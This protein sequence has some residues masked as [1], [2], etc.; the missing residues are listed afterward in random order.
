MIVSYYVNLIIILVSYPILS[1][2][3]VTQKWNII[4]KYTG[5]FQYTVCRNYYETMKKRQK[6]NHLRKPWLCQGKHCVWGFCHKKPC[7]AQDTRK[8]PHY[9]TEILQCMAHNKCWRWWKDHFWLLFT[10]GL[11]NVKKITSFICSLSL[12]LASL[13]HVPQAERGLTILV[14]SVF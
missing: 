11:G 2:N 9:Q 10:S 13:L 1:W 4:V 7:Q 12:Y 14:N 5:T 8:G 6:W 3:L